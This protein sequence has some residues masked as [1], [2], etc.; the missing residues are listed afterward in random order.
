MSAIA[1][2]WS[3]RSLLAHVWSVMSCAESEKFVMPCAESVE[4]LL[5]HTESKKFVM[6]CARSDVSLDSVTRL[7]RVESMKVGLSPK[8]NSGVRLFLARQGTH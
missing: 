2:V 8:N 5:A 7:V 3:A 6:P 4:F 1:H